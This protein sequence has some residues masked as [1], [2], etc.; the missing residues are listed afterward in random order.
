M[1][2]LIFIFVLM[3]VSFYALADQLAKETNEY[4][5]GVVGANLEFKMVISN[6]QNVCSG[7]YF[8]L[9]HKK[10]IP[11]FG[12]CA[13]GK[14]ELTEE[15]SDVSPR[16]RD[17]ASRFIGSKNGDKITGTWRSY[18]GKKEYPFAATKTTPDRREVMEDAKGEY[19]LTL[20]SGS[21]L[22]N[23]MTGIYK[24]NGAWRATGSENYGGR[25]EGYKSNLTK[26]DRALLS[27]FK[28]VVDE[29]LQ[30]RIYARGS[31][32]ADFPFRNQPTFTVKRITKTEYGSGRI[33]KYDNVNSFIENRMHIATTDDFLFTNYLAF[34]NTPIDPEHAVSVD[35][36]P[37]KQLFQVEVMDKKCCGST[38][39]DFAKR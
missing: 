12:V 10:A 39:L 34:D 16:N 5:K 21:Y 28:L 18:D 13:D 8:Y 26:S 20:I 29:S 31:V 14:F 6:Q 17:K 33:Y 3:Q 9:K 35:Y 38:S 2:R 11:L 25:R 37:I 24:E 19:Q 32:V 7:S 36:D 22:A 30:V 15:R 27:S 4:F 1:N 23:T